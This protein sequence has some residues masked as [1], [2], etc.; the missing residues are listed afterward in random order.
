M[1]KYSLIVFLLLVLVIVSYEGYRGFVVKHEPGILVEKFMS[2][3][4]KEAVSKY[5]DEKKYKMAESEKQYFPGLKPSKNI[6][7]EVFEVENYLH[8][9]VSGKLKLTFFKNRLLGIS[10]YPSDFSRYLKKVSE[11]T[12]IN[13]VED[14]KYHLSKDTDF[15]LRHEEPNHDIKFFRWQSR[16]LFEEYAYWGS[17]H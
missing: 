4:S 1:K 11:Q 16:P 14:E 9:N 7:I 17:N 2:Y 15:S 8:K 13:L 6:A 3:S 10:F 5:L 12:N